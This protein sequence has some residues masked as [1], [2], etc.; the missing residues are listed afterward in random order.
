MNHYS[1]EIRRRR[2]FDE[3]PE[4]AARRE[5]AEETGYVDGEWRELCRAECQ[6]P[7]RTS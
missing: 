1:W 7:S 6:L 2:D 3:F 4:A 5:L